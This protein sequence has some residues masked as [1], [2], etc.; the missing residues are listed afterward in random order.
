MADALTTSEGRAKLS[1]DWRGYE[2][3][4][5]VRGGEGH[6]E[7]SQAAGQLRVTASL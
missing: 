3:D 2:T 7:V 4:G 5:T 6:Q 1:V